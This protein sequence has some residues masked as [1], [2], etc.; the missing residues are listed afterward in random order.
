MLTIDSGNEP[1]PLTK[2]LAQSLGAGAEI[3]WD[4]IV[5]TLVH[6]HNDGKPEETKFYNDLPFLGRPV[7]N[8]RWCSSFLSALDMLVFKMLG[9]MPTQLSCTA[10]ELLFYWVTNNAVEH[11][12]LMEDQYRKDIDD[13]V[14]MI[15]EDEDFLFLFDPRFDGIDKIKELRMQSLKPEHWFLPFNEDRITHPYTWPESLA[16][17]HPNWKKFKFPR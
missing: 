4:N 3:L 10:E 15:L 7:L 1:Y 14:E 9:R 12:E 11:R 17:Y 2:K 6:L 5:E 8:G 13:Y 16:F